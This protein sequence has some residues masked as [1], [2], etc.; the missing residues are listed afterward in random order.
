MSNHVADRA[1]STAAI[2]RR[3]MLAIITTFSPSSLTT[4]SSS[5]RFLGRVH[6]NHR[7][8]RHAIGKFSEKFRDEPIERAAGRAPRLVIGMKRN[9]QPG[10][11]IQHCE[12]HSEFVEPL[13]KH[14]RQNLG[15]AL[16]SVLP[17]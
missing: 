3:T 16:S 4:Y 11:R 1:V 12:I 7:R 2:R 6:R 8:R 10:G 9:A 13:V 15:P 17:L 14:P 5:A